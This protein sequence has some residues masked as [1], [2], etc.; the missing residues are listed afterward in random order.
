M[1]NI[2]NLIFATLILISG[3]ISLNCGDGSHKCELHYKGMSENQIEMI[4]KSLSSK[5]DLTEEQN[6]KL[7]QI[8]N[9]IIGNKKDI[10]PPNKEDF[11]T[12][13]LQLIKK[14][15]ITA[16]ELDSVFSE[17]QKQ[18]AE[19]R[20]F[21]MKKLAEFHSILTAEQKEKLLKHVEEYKHKKKHKCDH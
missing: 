16:N 17:R 1:K 3:A 7:V 19:H 8:K 9:E 15:K 11:K 10:Q 4:A 13:L 12:K 2:K 5:L 18:H 21:M 20:M 6:K 14:D